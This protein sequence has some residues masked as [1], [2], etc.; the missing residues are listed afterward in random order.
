M[1]CWPLRV[2]LSKILKES[3][4]DST[5]IHKNKEQ[6]NDRQYKMIHY[7][8]LPKTFEELFTH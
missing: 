6:K 5:I 4:V 3:F 2:Y 7:K 1:G 8:Q